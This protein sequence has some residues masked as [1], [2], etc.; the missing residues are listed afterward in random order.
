MLKSRARI[1]LAVAIIGTITVLVIWQI[2]KVPA[3]ADRSNELEPSYMINCG[4]HI[5]PIT[6]DTAALSE[7]EFNDLATKVCKTIPKP[8]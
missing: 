7:D 8:L 4:N 1:D 3:P 5:I 6:L 2:N